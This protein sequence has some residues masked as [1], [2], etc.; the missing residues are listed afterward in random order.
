MYRKVPFIGCHMDWVTGDKNALPP[1]A[2]AAME[3]SEWYTLLHNDEPIMVGG[4]LQQ[5][6]GRWQVHAYMADS[7][8]RHMRYL[9]REAREYISRLK[10]RLELTV[11]VG[12]EAGHR[13][14]RMLGFEVETYVMKRYGPDGSDHTMWVRH[15]V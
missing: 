14:A 11:L 7:A 12:F 3:A 6:Q 15:N 5:W 10:G 8:G 4:A 1:E 9:T 13:W 2:I